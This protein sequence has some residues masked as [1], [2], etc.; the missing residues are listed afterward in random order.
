MSRYQL[1]VKGIFDN[2]IFILPSEGLRK[3]ELFF[4]LLITTMAI[5]FGYE[6]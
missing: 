1:R 5:S 6:V 2:L 4:G 3:L